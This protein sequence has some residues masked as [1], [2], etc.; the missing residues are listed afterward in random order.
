MTIIRYLKLQ[1]FLL[2]LAF[3]NF[4]ET[5]Y[6]AVKTNMSVYSNK[7]LDGY[8]IYYALYSRKD[9]ICAELY[10]YRNLFYRIYLIMYNL[11]LQLFYNKTLKD[12]NKLFK[13]E[14]VVE[15]VENLTPFFIDCAVIIYIQDGVFKYELLTSELSK[16]KLLHREGSKFVYA[17]LDD[18]LFEYDL[19]HSF[20]DFLV[21]VYNNESLNCY[22]IVTIFCKVT[23][24][25]PNLSSFSLKCMT[26]N[27]LKETIFKEKDIISKQLLS[28]NSDE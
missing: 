20:N 25:N 14:N 15:N 16:K 23:K 22:D 8:V 28:V 7:Q 6:N 19:T 9:G 27:T 21:G 5:S 11:V 13:L 17:V 26:E 12:T 4:C 2:F 18:E 10:D 24:T 3:I 1:F